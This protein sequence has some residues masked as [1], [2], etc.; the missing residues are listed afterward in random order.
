[1]IKP[2]GWDEVEAV[3]GEFDRLPAG[4]YVC[5]VI[6]AKDTT[7]KSGKPMLV[8][9][10]DVAEGKYKDYFAKQFELAKKYNPDTAKWRACSYHLYDIDNMGR[11][12]GTLELI[13]KC[14]PDYKWDW[15]EK[16]LKGKKIGV[17]FR[18][19]EYLNN[20]GQTKIALEVYQLHDITD[21]E[22][23]PVPE[24]KTLEP[25]AYANNF[26]NAVDPNEEVPF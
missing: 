16:T 22:N 8:L 20:N 12:K 7:S 10:L 24:K 19:R 5:K 4:G 21:I 2:K 15:D 26:G 17:I 13:L 3:T 18:E 11:L 1:M 14:N 6:Q 25:P 23:V 9:L